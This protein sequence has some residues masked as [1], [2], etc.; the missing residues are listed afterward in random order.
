MGKACIPGYC[1]CDGSCVK[2]RVE[3]VSTG[4]AA[5]ICQAGVV[6]ESV[7]ESGEVGNNYE[8]AIATW[9]SSLSGEKCH[10]LLEFLVVPSTSLT[11]TTF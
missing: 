6:R 1:K 11:R 7:R 3:D 8:R 9:R 5:E 4:V 2:N 10:L